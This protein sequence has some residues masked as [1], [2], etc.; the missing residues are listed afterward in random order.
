VLRLVKRE[1]IIIIF[2]PSYFEQHK[3]TVTWAAD[4]AKEWTAASLVKINGA[5]I[6][7]LLWRK[8]NVQACSLVKHT[9]W[10]CARGA[11]ALSPGVNSPTLASAAAKTQRW[12]TGGDEQK[13]ALRKVQFSPH[14]FVSRALCN[15]IRQAV[16][17]AAGRNQAARVFASAPRGVLCFP[18]E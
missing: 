6:V 17:T 7:L 11:V 18:F 14:W 4:Q 5:F 13:E 8:I 15:L 10:L 9:R 3:K 1:C 2:L 12:F 16:G